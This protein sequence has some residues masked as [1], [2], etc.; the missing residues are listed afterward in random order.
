MCVFFKLSY[1]FFK[2][3]TGDFYN[4]LASRGFQVEKVSVIFYPASFEVS[5]RRAGGTVCY[6]GSLFSV[7][8]L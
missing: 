2:S 8:R 4:I 5:S 7:Q 1:Y 6:A 3:A